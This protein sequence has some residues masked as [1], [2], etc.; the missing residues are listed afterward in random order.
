MAEEYRIVN[1]IKLPPK[2]R[3]VLKKKT[4]N[5]AMTVGE[6]S[7]VGDNNSLAT[8]LGTNKDKKSGNTLFSLR[9][10]ASR[11]DFC[12][13]VLV[14]DFVIYFLVSAFHDEPLL[15]CLITGLIYGCTI[16]LRIRRLY[17]RGM[18]GR[19]MLVFLAP[20]AFGIIGL[21]FWNANGV[22][23]NA[24][25]GGVLWGTFLLTELVQFISYG[26]IQGIW[27]RNQPIADE[28]VIEEISSYN[29][30][31]HGSTKLAIKNEWLSFGGSST[32]QDMNGKNVLL[33]KGKVFSFTRKKFLMT[34]GNRRLYTIRNKCFSLFGR[35]AFVLD[36]SG[37]EV[38]IVQRKILSY[39]DKYLVESNL[40][41]MEI[42]GNVL[43]YDYHIC[44][45]GMEIGHV[46]RKLSLRDSYVLDI[47]DRFDCRFFVALVIAID[48]ITDR[49]R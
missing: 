16:P 1:G 25:G 40:G 45:G 33:V 17:D 24:H 3:I 13:G 34:L 18:S 12:K 9:G 41:E 44:L 48:N 2:Q 39:D 29:E 36:G 49:R 19:W 30:L 20:L 5:T 31:S 8:D 32:V 46:E 28:N 21:L 26:C 35:T 11:K 6:N 14:S 27:G 47:N 42:T 22:F 15:A 10:R 37:K 43:G 38:A 7:C 23:W 4:V